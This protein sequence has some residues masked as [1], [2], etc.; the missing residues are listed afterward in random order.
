MQ[1]IKDILIDLDVDIDLNDTKKDIIICPKKENN[2]NE[3]KLLKKKTINIVWKKK[4]KKLVFK[5]KTK[6]FDSIVKNKKLKIVNLVKVKQVNID[7]QWKTINLTKNK[8]IKKKIK[9][10]NFNT[11]KYKNIFWFRK[12]IFLYFLYCFLFLVLFYSVSWFYLQKYINRWYNNLLKLSTVNIKE[13]DV[14][15]EFASIN[16]DFEKADMLIKPFLLIPNNNIKNVF[17]II[18]WW[19]H[20]SNFLNDSYLYYTDINEDLTS[21]WI[22]NINFL[23]LLNNWEYIYNNFSKDLEASIFYYDKVWY[24]FNQETTEK[25]KKARLLLNEFHDILTLINRNFSVLK[26]IFWANSERKYLVLLQNNDEIR[27]T[28]WFMWSIWAVLIKKWEVIDFQMDDIY[29]YEWEINK[30]YLDKIKA[31]EGINKIT[32]YFWIRDANNKISFNDSSKQIKYF[33]DYF[34]TDV[35]GLIYINQS[36]ILEFLD[37]LW[38][39]YFEKLDTKVDSSNFSTIMS[40]LVE[41]KTFKVWTLWTPKQVLFDFSEAFI[42]NIKEKWLYSKYGEIIFND[43]LTRDIVFNSFIWEENSLA[44]KLW[45]DWSISYYDSLDFNYPV[46]TSIW[47]WKTDRYIIRKFKKDV[48]I[49]EDCSIDTSF[50]ITQKHYFTNENEVALEEILNSFDIYNQEIVYIQGK[51][52]NKQFIQVVLP[53]DAIIQNPEKYIITKNSNN[54]VVKFYTSVERFQS[55]DSI[56]E[57]SLENKE[58][59]DY[60]YIL[61]KQAGLSNYN[62]DFIKGD[63]KLEAK[64]VDK[65]FVY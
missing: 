45:I 18:K 10:K 38:W 59:I 29:A 53:K 52:D 46:F 51:T 36:T 49:N 1:D 34:F 57:Y 12:K 6:H 2:T 61:Y 32:E 40:S 4:K 39:V 58:C 54:I 17:F 30:N 37:V 28:W 9:K 22:D 60:N 20:L 33:L 14:T 50:T 11:K 64:W 63:L 31:P 48:I 23:N 41:A 42:K 5:N 3:I 15:Q 26:N 16:N 19:F 7:N 47:W 35:D 65:D 43:I 27:P 25:F 56:I 62:I 55:L 21:W 44:W 13:T 24:L 8:E